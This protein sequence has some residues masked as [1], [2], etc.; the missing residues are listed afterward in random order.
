MLNVYYGDMPEAIYNPDVY[1]KNTY[2]DE[3][4]TD[5][6]SRELIQDPAYP[7]EGI[8]GRICEQMTGIQL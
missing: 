6:L 8:K 4:I 5:E 2:E 3:W 1:L 7:C